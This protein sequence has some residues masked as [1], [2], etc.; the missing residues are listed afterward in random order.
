M[1]KKY[2]RYINYIVNDIEVPY[3]IN[4]KDNYGL[5]PDEYELI[6]SKVYDQPVTIEGRNVYNTNGNQIYYEDSNGF[7]EKWEFD[8]NGKVIYYENS[9]GYWFKYEYD[10]DGNNIYYEDSNGFWSKRVYNTNGKVIYRENSNG[11][12]IDNR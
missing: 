8:A 7:W 11:V 10:N 6:L 2:E 1:N 5:S 3:F 4:M 12:I 9:K